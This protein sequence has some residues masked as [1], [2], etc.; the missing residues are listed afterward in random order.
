QPFGDETEQV[1]LAALPIAQ[2]QK[3]LVP[4]EQ[5]QHHRGQCALVHTDR[6]GPGLGL[7]GGQ[8]ADRERVWQYAHLGCPRGLA[9]PVAGARGGSV[10]WVGK[11]PVGSVGGSRRTAGARLPVQAGS[12]GRTVSSTAVPSSSSEGCPS[13]RGSAVC[14]NSFPRVSARPGE[15]SLMVS[16]SL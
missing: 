6:Y 13:N 3:V 4:F 8:G 2:H 14:A 5:V 9:R 16:A 7:L 11:E 12:M 15:P 1:G 10:S